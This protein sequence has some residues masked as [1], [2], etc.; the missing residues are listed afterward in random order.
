MTGPEHYRE[1]ER[2]LQHASA[3]AA[4]APGGPNSAEEL[5]VRRT[6]DLAEAQV[7]ATLALAAVIGLSADLPPG[8]VAAWRKAAAAPSAIRRSASSLP[9]DY[10][11]KA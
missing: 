7:H 2:L 6:A 5:A 10:T 3:M 11:G 9:G 8:D 4:V 1:A